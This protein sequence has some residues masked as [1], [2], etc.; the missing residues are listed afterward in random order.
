MQYFRWFFLS[1]LLLGFILARTP[2]SYTNTNN[3]QSCEDQGLLE[4]CSGNCFGTEYQNWIGDGI[5]DDESDGLD[6]LCDEWL[7]DGGDCDDCS[8]IPGGDDLPGQYCE[9]TDSDGLGAGDI[10]LFCDNVVPDGW[11]IDCSDQY[12]DCSAN[13]YDCADVCGGEALLDDCDVCSGGTT[14]HDQNSDIDCAGI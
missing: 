10:R 3:R 11:V 14:G 2:Q 12:P 8:G 13:F 4:D 5:C 7:F 9:D 1:T 6:F